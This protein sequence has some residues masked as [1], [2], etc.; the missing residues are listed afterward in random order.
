MGV[1][2]SE[3]AQ[4]CAGAHGVSKDLHQ[5]GAPGVQGEAFPV[6]A[7][8]TVQ[9]NDLRRLRSPS[10]CP[11]RVS[12]PH[13]SSEPT[14]DRPVPGSVPMVDTPA[15]QKC[16]AVEG[17]SVLSPTAARLAGHSTPF[18]LHGALR[19]RMR[20]FR[21]CSRR[22]RAR[23]RRVKPAVGPRGPTAR[24]FSRVNCNSEELC[25]QH[26]SPTSRT[27]PRASAGPVIP[28]AATSGGHV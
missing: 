8:A 25:P 20:G 10:T 17:N 1:V 7:R 5:P 23:M 6:A 15:A 2:S 3:G 26:P 27:L 13:R 22:R 11:L 18:T 24:R 16:F 19:S 14:A 4:L 28:R 12:S 9:F 21:R